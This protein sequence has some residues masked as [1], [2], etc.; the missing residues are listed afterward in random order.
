MSFVKLIVLRYL[1]NTKPVEHPRGFFNSTD[2]TAKSL[3]NV[4]LEEIRPLISLESLAQF[5]K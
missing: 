4:I 3:A 2:K 1:V 5:N